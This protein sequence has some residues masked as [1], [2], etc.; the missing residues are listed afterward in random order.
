MWG[1]HK[2]EA[3][4]GVFKLFD[5]SQVGIQ[6][7]VEAISISAE[8]EL[9]QVLEGFRQRD[10]GLVELV[11]AAGDRLMIGVGG[12]HACAQFTEAS[13]E[14]PYLMARGPSD[15]YDS[16]IEFSCGGTPTPIPLAYILPF[17]KMVDIA[18]DFFLNE[19]LPD[20]IEWEEV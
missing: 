10:P 16:H 4:M 14:L 1:Y 11:S 9:R 3:E 18:V 5:C 7:N 8:Q 19:H 13:G 17:S 2:G 20:I 12:E 6:R 15:D